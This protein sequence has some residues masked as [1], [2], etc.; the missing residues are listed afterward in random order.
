[1][2]EMP[3]IN[4]TLVWYYYICSRE[5]WLM[6]RQINPDQ[7]DANLDWGRYLH[8]QAY[9][10]D[11]KEVAVGNSKFDFVRTVDGQLVVSEIKKTDKFKKSATMQ[12]LF[13]LYTLRERGIEAKGELRFPEQ[14]KVEEVILTPEAEQELSLALEEISQIIALEMPPA[15]KKI[16]YCRSC[17]YQ[18]LCWA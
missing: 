4:G 10:R 16:K 8:Q 9:S 3:R 6:S 15:A 12:L 7:N 18:E 13:Y 5:V 11:K 2:R 17:A 14:K 1:M